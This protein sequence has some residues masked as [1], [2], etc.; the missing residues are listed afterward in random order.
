MYDVSSGGLTEVHVLDNTGVA[1][2]VQFSPDGQ[3]IA[4][5]GAD[6]YVRL[7]SMTNYEV[8]VRNRG[9]LGN[10]QILWIHYYLWETN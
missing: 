4:T 9:K 7:F 10:M 2:A 5:G 6:K 8:N 3:Y 1:S